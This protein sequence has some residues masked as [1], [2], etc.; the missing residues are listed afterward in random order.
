M[1]FQRILRRVELWNKS[2]FKPLRH[3]PDTWQL[4]GCQMS[5]LTS[6]R[7]SVCRNTCRIN[8]LTLWLQVGGLSAKSPSVLWSPTTMS[9]TCFLISLLDTSFSSSVAFVSLVVSICLP[10][11]FC[12]TTD[13]LQKA[14]LLKTGS[15]RYQRLHSVGSAC[16]KLWPWGF[17]DKR[18]VEL[19]FF[20]D[21]DNIVLEAEG[22][23][24]RIV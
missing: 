24:I 20:V 8:E 14:G 13:T 11:D 19:Y 21:V 2:L 10:V 7:R 18:I 5:E 9:L 3:K 17:V 6:L 16:G 23:H 22:W 15:L 12:V 4:H 1:F